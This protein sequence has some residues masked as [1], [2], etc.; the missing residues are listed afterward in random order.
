MPVS[1]ASRLGIGA[2]AVQAVAQE[3]CVYR[4]KMPRGD[5]TCGFKGFKGHHATRWYSLIAPPSSLRRRT[6]RRAERRLARSGRVAAGSATGAASDRCNAW[7]RCM[8]GPAGPYIRLPRSI[9]DLYHVLLPAAEP[10]GRSCVHGLGLGPGDLLAEGHELVTQHHDF[11]VLRRLAAAEQDQ[12]ANYPDHDQ[13]RQTDG[14]KL[15][16]CRT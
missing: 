13:V 8:T 9:P 4:S 14:Q 2:L 10:W 3:V 1:V 7:H 11:R 12:P 6:A 16:S 5:A 15:R